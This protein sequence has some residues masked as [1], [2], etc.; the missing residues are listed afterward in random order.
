[1]SLDQAVEMEAHFFALICP[2]RLG[3]S[4][5]L[6]Y[7]NLQVSTRVPQLQVIFGD[8]QQWQWQTGLT[9]RAFRRLPF[10]L[11]SI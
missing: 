5:S 3:D 6:V 8:R 2:G 10:K 4:S 11:L 9:S 1:M 7:S